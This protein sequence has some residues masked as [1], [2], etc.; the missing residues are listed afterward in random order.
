MRGRRL[1]AWVLAT[2]C[3][4]AAERSRCCAA[5]PVPCDALTAGEDGVAA[6]VLHMWL[7]IGADMFVGT[8]GSMYSDYIEKFRVADGRVD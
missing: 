1:R 6:A 8:R 4:D 2:D 7:C 5:G 3:D